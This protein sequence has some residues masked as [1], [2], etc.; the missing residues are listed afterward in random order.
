MVCFRAAAAPHR[1]PR[2]RP[3][4]SPSPRSAPR[5]ADTWL[6]QLRA[7]P[8]SWRPCLQ[9]LGAGGLAPHE[10]LFL[11]TTLKGACQKLQDVLD[12][13]ADSDLRPALAARL[14]AAAERQE[15]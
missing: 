11:A 5:A 14:R 12:P 8:G 3:P 4:S 9:L 1:A 15:G 7:A 6:S 13:A 10:A 2:A